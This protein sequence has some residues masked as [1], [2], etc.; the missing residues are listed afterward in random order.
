MAD[1]TFLD[2]IPGWTKNEKAGWHEVAGVDIGTPLLNPGQHITLT[3]AAFGTL[4][5]VLI[6]LAALVARSKYAKRETALVPEGKFSIRNLFEVIFEG[7]YGM[8]ASMMTEKQ[9]KRHFPIVASLGIFILA[10]NMIGMI[11]GFASPT[12]NLNTNVG[13]AIIVFIVYNVS[14]LIENKWDYVKHFFGPV[15]FIAP[16]IFVIEVI[17]AIV[18]PITLSLRLTGNIAGDHMVLGIFADLAEKVFTAPVLFPVPFYFLGLLVGVVQTVVFCILSSVYISL[19]V[20]H[21]EH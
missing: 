3:H 20:A 2:L 16:L 17:G 21:E 11:P 10:C 4:V 15:I 6:I 14:G 12:G 18:R 5:V 7:I 9:A 13:P 8:M 19:A 1:T